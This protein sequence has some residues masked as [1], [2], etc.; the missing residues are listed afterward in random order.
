MLV[1][2]IMVFVVFSFTGVAV[3]NVSYLSSSSSMETINNIKLQYAVESAVNESL[4]RINS[5]ADS[6]VNYSSGGITTVWD[7]STQVLSVNVDKFQMESEIL[8]DLSEDTHF[9]RGIAAQEEVYLDGN[10]TGLS[11]DHRARGRFGFLPEVDM[12]YFYENAVEVHTESGSWYSG[13][14]FANMTLADGIHIFEGNYVTLEDV[15]LNSGTIVLTGHH[16]RIWDE[17]HF[18]APPADSTGALPALVLT[19]PWQTLN[20]VSPYGNETIL[21]AIYCKNTIYLQNGNFSGPIVGRIVSM[22]E[23][24]DFLDTENNDYFQWTRGFGH[25]H[26][27]DWPKQIGRWRIQKWIKKQ[28]QT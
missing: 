14:S 28:L 5:G 7:S 16:I 19:H 22:S 4:W 12:E 26:H 1:A 17:N 15:I 21:G 24:F 3:L 20:L 13:V 18:T 9:D 11:D 2:V 10:I 27:Y 25:R 8:L 6:L 23:N